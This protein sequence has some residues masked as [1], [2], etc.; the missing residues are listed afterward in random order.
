MTGAEGFS[1]FDHVGDGFLGAA[2][3][4]HGGATIEEPRGGHR[5]LG[6]KPARKPVAARIGGPTRDFSSIEGLFIPF[7]SGKNSAKNTHES[8]SVCS[9]NFSGER[10]GRPKGG[11]SQDW[12]PYK[13]GSNWD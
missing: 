11:C 3:A 13:S 12:P 7:I 5:G 10:R 1:G 6:R 9:N 2:D 4:E 8:S